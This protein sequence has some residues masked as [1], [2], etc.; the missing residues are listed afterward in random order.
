MS[1]RHIS[2]SHC[3]FFVAL[4]VACVTLKFIVPLFANLFAGI[5]KEIPAPLGEVVRRFPALV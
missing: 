3:L 4:A 5:G 2:R 1:C